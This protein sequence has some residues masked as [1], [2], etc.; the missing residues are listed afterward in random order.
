MK[1]SSFV[2]ELFVAL[3]ASANVFGDL[4]PGSANVIIPAGAVI[5]TDDTVET[6]G[7]AASGGSPPF[8]TPTEGHEIQQLAGWNPGITAETRHEIQ[9]LA[10]WN[11]GITAETRHE[12]QQL[13]GANPGITAEIR[14]YLY[15]IASGRMQ[16]AR[17]ADTPN[18]RVEVVD[19]GE[20]WIGEPVIWTP[21]WIHVGQLT[22]VSECDLCAVAPKAFGDIV[23]LVRP[24]A[25]IV[26]RYSQKIMLWVKDLD[27]KGELTDVMQGEDVLD[28][29]RSFL[30]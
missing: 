5:K 15:F 21:F 26:A 10:G 29:I 23:A 22:A 2:L 9:Q 24:V 19:K 3:H 1:D 17:D 11:P 18:E 4:R 6:W 13:A 20:D 16:Y 28:L 27:T 25:A 8:F 14:S 12:F 7:D 30:D